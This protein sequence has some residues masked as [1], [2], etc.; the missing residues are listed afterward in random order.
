MNLII[1]TFQD[2][3]DLCILFPLK[4]NCS[5]FNSV[6][7]YP[8]VQDPELTHYVIFLIHLKNPCIILILLNH[9]FNYKIPY[10]NL[11]YDE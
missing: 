7:Q 10:K 8:Y 1:Q 4:F 2:S 3:P 5:I 11:N 6:F 9:S